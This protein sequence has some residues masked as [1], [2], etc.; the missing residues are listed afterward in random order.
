M[1]DKIN[2]LGT[3]YR[4]EVRK[5][6]EDLELKRYGRAGYCDRTTKSIVVAD[7]S[8][9]GVT[10]IPVEGRSDYEKEILRHEI[11]HAYLN[12]SG[13]SENSIVAECGWASNEEMIDWLAIQFPKLVKTFAECECI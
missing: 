8:E 7:L 10:D 13:L 6:S 2:V 1:T 5:I 9:E 3:E 11:I 4:V 12:E